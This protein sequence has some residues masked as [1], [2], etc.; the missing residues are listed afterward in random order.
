LLIFF[1][2][3]IDF[4]VFL[5]IF[6]IRIYLYIEYFTFVVLGNEGEGHD[7][8]HCP[9]SFVRVERTG[10]K[11]ETVELGTYTL[12]DERVTDEIMTSESS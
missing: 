5:C 11:N 1:I 3:F 9:C 6:C 4:L 7:T 10:G 12:K 2:D 8:N